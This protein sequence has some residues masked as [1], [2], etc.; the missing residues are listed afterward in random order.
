MAEVLV[1]TPKGGRVGKRRQVPAK[2]ITAEALAESFLNELIPSLFHKYTEHGSFAS[3]GPFEIPGEMHL[4][5][6]QTEKRIATITLT[7]E[8]AS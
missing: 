6:D 7:K 8:N 3:T 2:I 4:Y 5:C 1:A